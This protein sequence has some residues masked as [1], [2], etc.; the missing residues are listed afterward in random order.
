DERLLK[1]CR[2]QSA[3]KLETVGEVI[4]I[5][6][7]NIFATH[8]LFDFRNIENDYFIQIFKYIKIFS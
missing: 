4:D 5:A 1:Y 6:M 3:T 8:C 2:C 7:Q